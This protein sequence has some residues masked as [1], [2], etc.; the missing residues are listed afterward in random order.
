MDRRLRSGA[1]PSGVVARLAATA[2]LV[3]AA[4]A[5]PATPL[6]EDPVTEPAAPVAEDV[7]VTGQQ[8]G[9]GLWQ[10]SDGEHDL[11]ILGTLAPFPKSVVWHAPQV[12]S[13][14][15]R[16]QAVIGPPEAR[17]SVGAFRGLLL[18]P[19]WLRVRHNPDGQTLKDV[20][21]ADVYAH[22]TQLKA[23]Y[24]AGDNGVERLRPVLAA[25]AL[26]ERAIARSDLSGDDPVWKQ[27]TVTARKHGVAILPVQVVTKFD[28]PKLAL[29]QWQ[30][31]PP[32]AEAKCFARTLD[33][34]ERDV[35]LLRR[36]ANL[37]SVG[38]VDALR[39]LEDVDPDAP[40]MDLV[41]SIASLNDPFLSLQRKMNESWLAAATAALA[42]NRTT[43][44]VLPLRK[45]LEPDGLLQRLR[46]RGLTVNPP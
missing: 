20:L 8:A 42:A 18:L 24:L 33:N 44:A 29:N 3:L 19:T 15:T 10:V 26:Y 25:Q 22:W 14:L 32:P 39:E 17:V 40:C 1:R 12:E 41:R 5:V 27:V 30:Q 16:A 35:S 4:S 7:L 11:W 13:L 46:E 31:L 34:L 38:D 6:R 2:A 21:P 23:R 28:D 45:L 43:V 37:W 36:R 9:P